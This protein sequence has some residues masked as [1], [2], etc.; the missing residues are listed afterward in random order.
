MKK[1]GFSDKRSHRI[2]EWAESPE[3]PTLPIWCLAS[4]SPDFYQILP[5]YYKILK[6][7]EKLLI[8]R[9]F[10]DL[11]LWNT[12]IILS[13]RR[14]LWYVMTVQAHKVS[15]L[16][17]LS[18]KIMADKAKRHDRDSSSLTIPHSNVGEERV[19]SMIRKNKTDFRSN[20]DLRRSL[21]SI[22]TIKMNKPANLLPCHRFK[23]SNSLLTKCKAACREYNRAHATAVAP[24]WMPGMSCG[25]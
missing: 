14:A 19:F 24:H 4:R 16:T 8:F 22:M 11:S 13:S 3:I 10:G 1:I 7:R 25:H 5:I 20:L 9:I 18:C 2:K 15:S 6:T 23:P 12:H 17:R 21:S